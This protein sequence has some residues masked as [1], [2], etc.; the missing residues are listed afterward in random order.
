MGKTDGKVVIVTGASRGIGKAIAERFAAEGANVVCVARTV[1]EGD[2]RAPGALSTTLEGIRAAG[3]E[4]TPV[5][6]N[7]GEEE[8][9]LRIVEETRA[10]YGPVDILVNNAVTNFGHQ[11]LQEHGV[12]AEPA[13][14]PGEQWAV[15]VDHLV[16]GARLH[17][18]PAGR[19]L[20]VRQPVARAAFH[21]RLPDL[22]AVEHHLV[23]PRDRVAGALA[24]A[25]PAVVA[26]I[27]EA[28]IDRLVDL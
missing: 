11:G 21:V 4:A 28:E 24:G 3:G 26:E 18:P 16:Q 22:V 14:A 8:E 5:V 17:A 13:R 2:S 20:G 10:A 9:C 7:L 27:L 25:L 12:D 15:G 23:A 1:N 6:A 19:T